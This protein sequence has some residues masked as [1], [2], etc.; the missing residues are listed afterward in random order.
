MKH[1]LL[2]RVYGALIGSAIGD[3]MGGPVEGLSY[4]IIEKRYGRV[5]SLLPYTEVTPSY[6]GPFTTTAGSYTDDTRIAILLAE[7]AIH[8]GGIPKQGDIT[9]AF[10]EY[11]RKATTALERGFIEEYYLKGLY[12]QDKEAFGGLPTTGGIMGIAPLG[13]I[14]PADPHGAFAHVFRTLFIS[15]GTARTAS[16]LAAAMIAAAMQPGITWMG[17]IDEALA[18]AAA[19]KRAVEANG[20]R[21]S[22]LYPIV[23]QKSEQLLEKAADLGGSVVSVNDLRANLHDAVVQDFFADGSETLA[24]AAA[25][26]CAARGDFTETV[27]GC[28][29]FGRDNDS[30]AAVGG[31]VAGALCGAETIPAEWIE[32]VERANPGPSLYRLAE[33]LTGLTMQRISKSR[34]TL[35]LQE[36]L[37]FPGNGVPGSRRESVAAAIFES[38]GTLDQLLAA[39]A[40]PDLPDEKGSHALHIAATYGNDPALRLLLAYG[41]DCNCRDANRTTPLH[42]AAWNNHANTVKLLLEWGADADL[43]EGINWTPLHDAVRRE[44]VDIALVLLG[45]SRALPQ[46]GSRDER[47]LALLK[48]L[49]EHQVD[50][51]AVGICGQS[52]LHDAVERGYSK[53]VAFL[54]ASGADVNR[55]ATILWE[56]R[57]EGTPLHKAAAYGHEAIYAMLLAAGGDETVRNIDGKTPPE[58]KQ[59]RAG[60]EG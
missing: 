55:L 59:L 38:L 26:F 9:Y 31:A 48:L 39:G 41:A 3:A 12:G 25:N 2:D 10:A 1:I 51:D 11:Y 33:K 28:V 18:A 24:L 23:A 22:S 60:S 19:S 15:T 34:N 14:F 53:S 30:S 52:L 40:D 54:I 50:L 32:L 4:E 37:L 6:H 44:Y 8:A 56:K 16:A 17:V 42:F 21:S 47:F 36:Q 58:L 45:N 29:N 5:N 35:R 27:I 49:W 20:W 43:S 57:F 13:A 7:A 46:D